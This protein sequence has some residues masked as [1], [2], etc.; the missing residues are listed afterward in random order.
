MDDWLS[1]LLFEIRNN[2]NC[3]KGWIYKNMIGIPTYLD[4]SLLRTNLDKYLLA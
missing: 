2:H 1:Q 3:D 4:Y